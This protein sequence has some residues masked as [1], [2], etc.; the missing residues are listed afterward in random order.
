M[1]DNIEIL[2]WF[3]RDDALNAAT[4]MTHG[5]LIFR[6]CC[7][8]YCSDL[9]GFTDDVDGNSTDAAYALGATFNVTLEMTEECSCWCVNHSCVYGRWGWLLALGERRIF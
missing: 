4:V 9:P 5:D 1:A 7:A 6:Y 8:D 3:I 2:A